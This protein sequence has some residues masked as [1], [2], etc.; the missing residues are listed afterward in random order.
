MA[1][2]SVN[3]KPAVKPVKQTAKSIN[4]KK[5]SNGYVVSMYSDKG[6]KTVIASNKKDAQDA[7]NKMLGL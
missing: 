6:E 4:L 7:A 3:K 1:K 2:K 5:V